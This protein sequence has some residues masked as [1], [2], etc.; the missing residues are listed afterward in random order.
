MNNVVLNSLGDD[1]GALATL[2]VVEVSP[3]GS[4]QNPQLARSRLASFV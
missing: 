3:D 2:Q 1:Q 4:S